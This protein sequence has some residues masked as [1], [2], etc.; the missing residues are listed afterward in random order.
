M[1]EPTAFT[2]EE[3]RSL[4]TELLAKLE[5]ARATQVYAVGAAAAYYA[6]LNGLQDAPPRLSALW[7]VPVGIAVL[8]LLRNLDLRNQVKVI[9][10]YLA[11][12]EE[13][14]ADSRPEQLGWEHHLNR[15]RARYV[16]LSTRAFWVVFIILT[17]VLPF[18]F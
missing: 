2:L 8:G 7:F 16:S 11:V 4:R 9:G 10:E 5:A 12:I 17:G 18:V 15:N 13:Q 14:V 3:Y 6:W 1:P